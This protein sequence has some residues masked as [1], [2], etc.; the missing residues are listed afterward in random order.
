MRDFQQCKILTAKVILDAVRFPI[1]HRRGGSGA[2]GK[3]YA[4]EFL[5]FILLVKN[6]DFE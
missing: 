2:P 6:I 4:L 3:I 5:S 1:A